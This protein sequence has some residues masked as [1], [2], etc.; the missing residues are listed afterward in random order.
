MSGDFCREYE[1][2]DSRKL[3]VRPMVWENQEVRREAGPNGFA[4][5][6]WP[7]L[8]LTN[9]KNA[10]GQALH[11]PYRTPILSSYTPH[12]T[13]CFP[14]TPMLTPS[15]LMFIFNNSFNLFVCMQH[16]HSQPLE[17]HCAMV[18]WLVSHIT[19]S[20]KPTPMPMQGR[21]VNCKAQHRVDQ[22]NAR[23]NGLIGARKS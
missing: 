2:R 14:M 18:R 23:L 19:S 5:V 13:C 16:G 10:L 4:S 15:T 6:H 20:P 3:E 21:K 8:L 7:S 22:T 1:L 9:I 11:T 12:K 17:F